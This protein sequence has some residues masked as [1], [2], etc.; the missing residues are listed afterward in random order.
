MPSNSI[1]ALFYRTKRDKLQNNFLYGNNK[2]LQACLGKMC[3][4]DDTEMIMTSH[5]ST[6]QP[7]VLHRLISN[8]LGSHKPLRHLEQ[9][10]LPEQIPA[11][12][13]LFT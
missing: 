11:C 12:E 9:N 5:Y 1:Q 4:P 2:S 8:F 7:L 13:S 6:T 3:R 10:L